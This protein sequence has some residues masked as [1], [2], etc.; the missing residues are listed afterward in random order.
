[1]TEALLLDVD[2]TE[3]PNTRRQAAAEDLA[4][5]FDGAAERLGFEV[6]GVQTEIEQAFSNN[7]PVQ[8]VASRCQPEQ[9]DSGDW[10]HFY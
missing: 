10:Y 8:P 5:L 6:S 2:T 9:L 7:D 1:M 4:A 3:A